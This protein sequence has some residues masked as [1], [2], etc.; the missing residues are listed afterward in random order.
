MC[1][2]FIKFIINRSS[3]KK[4]NKRSNNNDD[5]CK[6][7]DTLKIIFLLDIYKLYLDVYHNTQLQIVL[8][9]IYS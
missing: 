5:L 9:Y 4:S 7:I 8:I 6:I 1:Q 3:K 2:I